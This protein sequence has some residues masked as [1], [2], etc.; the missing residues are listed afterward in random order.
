MIKRQK[1]ISKSFWKVMTVFSVFFF[2]FVINFGLIAKNQSKSGRLKEKEMGIDLDKMSKFSEGSQA[3]NK[4][5]SPNFII[6][7]P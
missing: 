4:S 5:L 1:I 6:R 7:S 3:V 2:L